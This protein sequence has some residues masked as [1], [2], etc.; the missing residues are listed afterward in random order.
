MTTKSTGTGRGREM[1]A[2]RLGGVIDILFQFLGNLLYNPEKA[3]LRPDE[4]PEAFQPFGK[5]LL[6]FAQKLNE[7]RNFAGELSR[8]NLGVKLPPTDNEFAAP[9]KNL[10][11]SLKHLT[12]QTQQVAKGDYSQRVDFMG[13][14]SDA[15]N[16]MIRLLDERYHALT[17]EIENGRQKTRAL[18]QNIDLF[19]AITDR[20]SQWI[21][22]L[23]RDTGTPLFSNNAMAAIME[24][25]SALAMELF[26]WMRRNFSRGVMDSATHEEV[27]LEA[28]SR[29]WYLSVAKYQ[30]VWLNHPAAVFSMTD[31]SEEH[32]YIE[33]LRSVAEQDALTQV[34]S[35]HFGMRTLHEWVKNHYEF[36]ICFVDM[37]FLKYV[38]DTFGHQAGDDYI[39]S[40][41]RLLS[42]FSRDV[43]VNRLGGDEFMLLQRDWDAARAEARMRELAKELGRE[44][45]EQGTPYARSI[46][47]GVVYVPTDNSIP[48]SDLLSQADEKMYLF[49][50]QNKKNRGVESCPIRPTGM[51]KAGETENTAG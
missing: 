27:E 16:A 13:D 41:A 32:R 25:D 10:H 51:V 18:E 33:E 15:F 20:I 22:V 48:A 19:K 4:L 50:R 31:V 21:I 14:F 47:Y 46:S 24:K 29:T 9:L 39:T 23:D 6:F 1:D 43:M 17:E 2:E 30:L 49:K 28:G 40:V 26:A 42:S 36:C 5:G 44:D 11:A 38:N 12:W 37:D 3:K 35:R 7:M 34:N 8:G 45:R